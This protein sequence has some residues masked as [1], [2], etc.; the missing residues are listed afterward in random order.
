[1]RPRPVHLNTWEGFY[2]DHDEA[3]LRDLADAAAKAGIERFVLDDGWFHRRND[4][5]TSLGDWWPDDVKYPNGLGPL[6]DHVTGLGMEFGLWVEP[7]MINPDSE[8]Y[9]AHPD[10]ALQ[11]AGR[12]LITA[13][14][15]LVLD[16]GRSV[17][18]DATTPDSLAGADP[19]DQHR[20]P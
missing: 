5:T 6:A 3:A 18:P 9:R 13:R 4:D 14:N 16:M 20:G 8:L 7:E 12:P 15:Q 1:M 10:W 19:G 11:I 2:F 17:S